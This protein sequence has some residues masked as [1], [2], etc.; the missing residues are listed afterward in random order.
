M[1]GIAETLDWARALMQLHRDHLD[2]EAIE[3]TLGCVLKNYH[4]VKAF[5][6][7]ETKTLLAEVE[8]T[9]R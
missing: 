9:L 1:P 2:P 7:E 8:R 5:G 6:P 4:D 3:E